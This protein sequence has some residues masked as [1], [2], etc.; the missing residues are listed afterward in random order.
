MITFRPITEDNFDAIIAMRR[1]EDENFVASNAESLAQCWLYRDN[2]DVFPF[3]IYADEEPVG[4]LLLEEDMDEN[5]LILW[6]IMFPPEHTGKGY[7]TQA[8]QLLIKQAKQS[9]K[10]DVILLDCAPDNPIARHV[11]EKAGFTPTGKIE[12]RSDEMQYRL[13]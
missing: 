3:A 5:T 13:K 4:F 9:G 11:Y 8:V 10:Y 6:R 1:P 7:G 12:H 2:N